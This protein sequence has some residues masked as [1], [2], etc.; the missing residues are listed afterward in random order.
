MAREVIVKIWCDVCKHQQP[1]LLTDASEFT[2]A[3]GTGKSKTLALC[4]V[5][6]KEF[7][8]PLREAYDRWAVASATPVAVTPQPKAKAATPQPPQVKPPR[9]QD[10][11]PAVGEC[12]VCHEHKSGLGGH[13]RTQHQA[14]ER[15]T[16][17]Q[18]LGLD[19]PFECEEPGCRLGFTN[20]A[21]LA[22]HRRNG[23][24]L[25]PASA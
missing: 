25:E 21:G 10:L 3:F 9:A 2:A 13:W 18:A 11:V 16:L 4:K 7:Y 5:H 15:K 19:T 14:T 6:V 8:A 24:H 1:E 17:A 22:Q 23:A 12:P 20:G